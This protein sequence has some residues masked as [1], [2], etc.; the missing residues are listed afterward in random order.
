[1][2]IFTSLGFSFPVGS[3]SLITS[4]DFFFP[5]WWVVVINFH[6]PKRSNFISEF[7]LYWIEE[8]HGLYNFA[9][10]IIIALSRNTSKPSRVFL[11]CARTR[12][13]ACSYRRIFS[14][15]NFFIQSNNLLWRINFFSY[16]YL[17]IRQFVYSALVFIYYREVKINYSQR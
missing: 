11:F 3:M 9:Q 16:D 2:V 14:I 1:M 7:Q 13:N 15:F 12:N 5:D 17:F 4:L 6:D 8:T 10:G